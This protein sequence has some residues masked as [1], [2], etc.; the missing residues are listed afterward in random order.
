MVHITKSVGTPQNR[1]QMKLGNVDE[2]NEKKKDWNWERGIESERKVVEIS[3]DRVSEE[4]GK[5]EEEKGDRVNM[6]TTERFA[7]IPKIKLD[8]R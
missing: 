2:V 1:K 7:E 8:R 4:E 6:E 3:V 5:D